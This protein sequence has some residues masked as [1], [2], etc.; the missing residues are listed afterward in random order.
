[1]PDG[2]RITIETSNITSSDIT[3]NKNFNAYADN[4]VLLKISDTGNGIP[5]EIRQHIFEPFFTTKETGKGTGLGLAAVY[6]AVQKH[7]GHINVDSTIGKGTVFSIYL[8]LLIL[9]KDQNETNNTDEIYGSGTILLIDDE[10]IIRIAGESV[11]SALGYKVVTAKD[12]VEG[13]EKFK[14]SNPDLVLLD[15]VMPNMSSAECFQQLQKIN[16]DIPIIAVSGFAPDKV[17]NELLSKG[18]TGFMKKPYKIAEMSRE[19]AA[20]LKR[21]R[22]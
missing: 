12:G 21:N 15:M 17:I 11:I 16:P 18:L 19:I 20:A 3:N 7:K 2:G 13:I 10:E 5:A 9:K 22:A 4:Y 8:P 14:E 1:M 6:G